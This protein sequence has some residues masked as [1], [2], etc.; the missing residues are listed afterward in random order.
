MSQEVIDQKNGSFWNELCGTSLAKAIGVTEKDHNSLQRFDEEYFR[1]YPYLKSYVPADDMR[2]KRTLEMGL[3]YGTLSQYLVE[4]GA[5]YNGLDIAS[6]A[7]QMVNNRIAMMGV[8]N[9]SAQVGSALEI[10]FEDNT[11]DYVYS[12]GCLHHT[13]D[14]QKSI[15]EVHRVLKPGGQSCIMIYNKNSFRLVTTNLKEKVKSVFVRAEKSKDEFDERVRGMFDAN[16]DGEAAPHIDYTS[17]REAKKIFG[18]F[19]SI[20]IDR[21][22][23]DPLRLWGSKYIPREKLLN[24]LGRLMGLDLYIRADKKAA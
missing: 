8:T 24:N 9:S 5:V 10:P 1:I 12:I 18:E 14:L 20:K 6:E 15:D 4:C 11:F 22:N 21:Q 7:V 23:S 13:G 19:Q 16:G 17:I 3:G 2:G